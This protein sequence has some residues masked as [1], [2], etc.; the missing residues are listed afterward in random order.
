MWAARETEIDS[1]DN[2]MF[3]RDLIGLVILNKGDTKR[4][5]DDYLC[6]KKFLLRPL[7]H[8]SM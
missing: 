4:F 3:M 8:T 5:V 6:L 1:L 7:G 2:L